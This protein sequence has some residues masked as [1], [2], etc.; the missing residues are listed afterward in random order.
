MNDPIRDAI[1]Y[2]WQAN[3]GYREIAEAIS[4]QFGISV[5]NAADRIDDYEMEREG[6]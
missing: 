4:Q 5:F 2:Y 1:E 6:K 3:M